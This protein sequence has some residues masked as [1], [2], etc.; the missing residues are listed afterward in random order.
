[1]TTVHAENRDTVSKSI[2]D[3]K[4]TDVKCYL[5]ERPNSAGRFRWRNGLAGS[6]DGTPSSES[7]T[8]AVLRMDTDVGITASVEINRGHLIGDLTKRRFK[9]LIGKNAL[10]TEELW[11]EIWELDRVEELH[12][13]AL[14]LIDELAWDLK[15]QAAGLPIYQ[16]LGGYKRKFPAYA[17]T[18]TWN[19]M[20]EYE[21]YIKICADVG[22]KAF[23]LH[24]WG[25]P[26]EDALLSR[27]LR[28]WVG[29]DAELM[30]DGSAGWDYVTSLEFGR[31]LEGENFVWYEE[32]MREF[33]LTSYAK[34]TEKLDI[35]IL[36]CETSD[37]SHWNAATWIDMKA[38]DM[39]RTS[40]HYKGGIT[41]GMKIAHLAESHG[42]RA[43]VHG[44]GWS[45]AHICAAIPNNDYYE[46]LV[47]DEPQIRSGGAA[48]A[49]IVKDGYVELS[50]EPGL[51][52][53]HDWSTLE[54]TAIAI[55]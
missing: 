24:A 36:A 50:D 49:P 7:E 44:M 9:S 42:M 18:V 48:G 38:L 26:K 19:T 31:V 13:A 14:G 3:A 51:G 15:S 52:E 47:I 11:H 28:K 29:P 35:P 16:L 10:M 54:K 2:A 20:D 32:P 37:G 12:M 41:G 8:W 4:I 6:G 33:D 46:Q 21:R 17:S 53:T 1:M 5:I 30:F 40:A 23:K 34:L 25:D 55:I 45:N 27:N 43:Q 39:M 22:Y